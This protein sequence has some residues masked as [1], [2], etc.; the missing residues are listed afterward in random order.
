MSLV[1]TWKMKKSI[2]RSEAWNMFFIVLL[3]GIN[4]ISRAHLKTFKYGQTQHGNSA[5]SQTIANNE[6]IS[7][8]S[9]NS[10]E[11]NKSVEEKA[12]IY[13]QNPRTS[14]KYV[15]FRAIGN[16]LPPRHAEDQTINNLKHILKYEIKHEDFDRR[17]YVNK[18]VDLGKLSQIISLLIENNETFYVDL[19]NATDYLLNTDYNNLQMVYNDNR[20]KSIPKKV[21]YKKMFVDKNQYIIGNNIVRNRMIRLGIDAQAEYVLPF[22]GNC[23][24]NLN[25]FH[26][27]H[28]KITSTLLD[29]Y[30]VPMIRL[31]NNSFA[32]N[33]SFTLTKSVRTEEP[34]IIFSRNSKLR[35]N[36]SLYYGFIPKVALLNKIRKLSVKKDNHASD[37]ENPDGA[38]SAGWTFRLFSGEKE[39]EVPNRAFARGNARLQGLENIFSLST[40]KAVTMPSNNFSFG[41]MGLFHNLNNMKSY[42]EKELKWKLQNNKMLIEKGIFPTIMSNKQ[43]RNSIGMLTALLTKMIKS[44]GSNS[45]I[46]DVGRLLHSIYQYDSGRLVNQNTFRD[47]LV[48]N[49]LSICELFDLT[50]I[51]FEL[52]GWKSEF[53]QKKEST[54]NMAKSWARR[55]SSRIEK[56]EDEKIKKYYSFLPFGR[57]LSQLSG[58]AFELSSA[59]AHSFSANDFRKLL[60][61]TSFARGR[62]FYLTDPS[63]DEMML[64]VALAE[65]GDTIGVNIWTF[66]NAVLLRHISRFGKNFENENDQNQWKIQW[67]YRKLS[68]RG[69]ASES[70]SFDEIAQ[71]N[72]SWSPPLWMRHPKI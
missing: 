63:I 21:D 27:I 6:N 69:Y 53:A 12:L 52:E 14:K 23:F 64:W 68:Q 72:G 11:Y 33:N 38:Y 9:T 28:A 29:Y 19:F 31:L 59:C 56:G 13:S 58:I 39:L 42:D 41:K 61:R 71:D 48:A 66:H 1:S 20:N 3:I 67:M 50:S 54:K 26:S 47:E 44:K 35:F 37:F 16:D 17:F 45:D 32:S 7:S 49:A 34:Q 62:L 4:L 15:L 8:A 25:A 55:Y 43:F 57:E 30:F 70:K 2:T 5:L 36:E 40:Y 22:D 51:V 65:L 60:R 46:R 18:I 24:F 10:N